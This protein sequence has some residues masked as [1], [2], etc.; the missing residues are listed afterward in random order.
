MPD[1]QIQLGLFGSG[2]AAPATGP[3]DSPPPAEIGA[4]AHDHDHPEQPIG[5][6]E[7]R[8]LEER[9]CPKRAAGAPAE[10]GV[11]LAQARPEDVAG[12][13]SALADARAA[14]E[15]A[16]RVKTGGAGDA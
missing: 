13:R 10:P 2:R 11:P 16:R 7:A 6:V 3:P 4:K 1:Q 14:V 12:G 5:G 8:Q 15:A 9:T